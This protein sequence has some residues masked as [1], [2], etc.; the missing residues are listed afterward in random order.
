MVAGLV[1]SSSVLAGKKIVDHAL[2]ERGSAKMA[3]GMVD[4]LN[5]IDPAEADTPKD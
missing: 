2:F 3:E 4:I 1:A 5:S